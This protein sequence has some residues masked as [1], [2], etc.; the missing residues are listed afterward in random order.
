MSANPD[1]FRIDET[2]KALRAQFKRIRDELSE[3]ERKM[4]D[5]Q[6]AAQV[7]KHP[8]F[9][10][11]DV[12]FAYISVGTEVDTRE[13]IAAAWASGKVVAAPRVIGP[14]RMTW[15]RLSSFDDLI[16]SSF[17]VL[18]P[19]GD[20]GTRVDA[21]GSERSVALVPGHVFDAEGYRI[22]Y[23]GGFYDTF[24]TAFAGT[25]LG[26]IRSVQTVPTLD[27]RGAYDLPV[28]AV[29]TEQ[30]VLAGR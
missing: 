5:A 2:K 14:R 26:I 21:C 6:I 25:S 7:Q 27:C 16:L 10:D 13:L 24:L 17:G 28:N 1:E 9:R 29:V 30:G 12:V 23:G 20:D 19:A 8:A 22:G 3:G 18:E 11:A 4:I 15:H